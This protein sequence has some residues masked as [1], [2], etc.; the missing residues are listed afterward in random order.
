[1]KKFTPKEIKKAKE[2]IIVF[3]TMGTV[4]LEIKKVL[5]VKNYGWVVEG[6]VWQ[7]DS[8]AYNM[9]EDY[10][11]EYEYMNFP[12]SCIKKLV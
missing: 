7:E 3:P 10:Y 1:M 9:P 4:L 8:D 2:A 5:N 6:L 12:I 11:G